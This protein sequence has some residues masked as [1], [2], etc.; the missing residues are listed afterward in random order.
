M[1]YRLSSSGG[2][3]QVVCIVSAPSGG[4]WTAVVYLDWLHC[5]C[6]SRMDRSVTIGQEFL[7]FGGTEILAEDTFNTGA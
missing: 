6:A 4:Y 7:G 5:S 1:L 3:S 2:S